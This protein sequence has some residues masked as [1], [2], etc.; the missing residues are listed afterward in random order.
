MHVTGRVAS[1][2]NAQTLSDGR[3]R[4]LDIE[5]RAVTFPQGALDLRKHNVQV[6]WRSNKIDID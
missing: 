3:S 4:D 5:G 6:Y 2:G 1:T